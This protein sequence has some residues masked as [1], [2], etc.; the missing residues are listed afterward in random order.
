MSIDQDRLADEAWLLGAR[1]ATVR[2]QEG[3]EVVCT[4]RPAHEGPQEQDIDWTA[5]RHAEPANHLLDPSRRWLF[6]LP[7]SVRPSALPHLYPRI[8]NTLAGSWH[9]SECLNVI[10]DDLL[11]DHR[12]NRAGFPPRVRVELIALWRYWRS[13]T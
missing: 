12:G 7:P 1:P 5:Y 10:F 9:D 4:D 3:S 8:V 11:I 2:H 13:A 6:G